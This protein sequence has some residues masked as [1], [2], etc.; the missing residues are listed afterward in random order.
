M[1]DLRLYQDDLPIRDDADFTPID[2]R[3]RTAHVRLKKGL[4][5]FYAMASRP[6]A[7]RPTAAPRRSRSASTARTGPAASTSSP[8]AWASIP[9]V[10]RSDSRLDAG[11]VV[12]YLRGHGLD[13]EVPGGRFLAL[14]DGEVTRKRVLAELAAIREEARPEDTVVLFLA[15]HADVLPDARREDAFCLLL[16]G[17]AFPAAPP[18]IDGPEI[19]PYAAMYRLLARMEAQRRLVV[20]DA[21]R[22]RGDRQPDG[23]ADRGAD[24]G[25]GRRRGSPRPHRLPPGRARRAR[26]R[27]PGAGPWPPHARPALG[28]R[29]ARP[30]SGAARADA[31]LDGDRFVTTEEL[32]LFAGQ[33]LPD[34]A[35]RFADDAAR[36][37]GGP[38]LDRRP[39]PPQ[40]QGAGPKAFPLV[41]LPK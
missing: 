3:D 27:G 6:T 33:T 41:R 38:A 35:A 29:L 31:D 11:A 14:K 28:A 18:P 9:A 32:R 7:A 10:V 39:S 2:P 17:F 16:S 8:S 20:I 30:P 15:G 26:L 23:P 40:I 37:G 25:Q 13:P 4:N 19:L 12:D 22:R 34:L 36:A 1:A 5:R 24:G 21:C